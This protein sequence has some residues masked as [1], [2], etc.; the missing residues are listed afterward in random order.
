MRAVGFAIKKGELWFS[1]I[2]GTTKQDA[3]IVATGKHL[4]QTNC[5]GED[6]SL[7]FYNMFSEIISQYNP[8]SIACKVHLNSSLEQIPY[9]HCPLGLLMYICKIKN[10]P[11]TMRSGS[12]ITAGKKKKI[13][14]CQ[15]HFS[16]EKLSAEKLT[17]VLVAWYQ[18]GD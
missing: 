1:V 13:Q 2:D 18:F 7:N 5:T 11:V 10:V 9:M 16:D 8:S 17:A 3:T 15:E 12:W 6:L 4:F 14:L